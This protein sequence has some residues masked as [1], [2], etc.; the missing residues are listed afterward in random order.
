MT[1]DQFQEKI[2]HDPEFLLLVIK[3]YLTYGE[4]LSQ[5]SEEFTG[6][7]NSML[8]LFLNYPEFE[9][10]FF[11]KVEEMA[12]VEA[13][14]LQT[15]SMVLALREL[16]NSL[17]ISRDST[18][19]KDRISAARGIISFDASTRSKNK[20]GAKTELEEL[21]EKLENF[22]QGEKSGTDG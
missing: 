4:E 21:Y 18:D 20:G 19:V 15:R 11:Q 6:E 14:R 22:K 5:I 10:L 1:L 13:K 2:T 16:N 9:E 3:K 17:T 8:F 7:K 12:T